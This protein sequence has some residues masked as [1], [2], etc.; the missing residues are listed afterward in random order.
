MKK[1]ILLTNIQRFSLHDGPG[2]RT[3]VFLKG[4]LLRCPWCSNP[5]NI[6]G[7]QESYEKD[8]L[9][10]V[11]GYYLNCFELYYEVMKDVVYYDPGGVTFSGGEPLLQ[12]EALQPLMKR[13]CQE[14]IHQSMETSLFAPLENI[15]LTE[16]FID[17]FYVDIKLLDKEK[18]K[19]LLQGDMA[20]YLKNVDWLISRGKNIVFRIPVISPYTDTSENLNKVIRF[21]SYYKVEYVELICGHNLGSKKYESLGLRTPVIE[22]TNDSFIAEYKEKI[23]KLGIRARICR[24]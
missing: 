2:I 11:Y 18:C 1:D 10:G 24:I 16:E 3:T 23:E 6:H 8:G 12:A 13:L 15:T 7:Y 20:V 14:K 22:E 19:K 4:C 17:I 9:K 21:L 5:E